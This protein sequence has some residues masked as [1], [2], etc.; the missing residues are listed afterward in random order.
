M[1]HFLTP[2]MT[3]FRCFWGG[4][5]GTPKMHNFCDILHISELHHFRRIPQMS[6]KSMK[7]LWQCS[8]LLSPSSRDSMMTLRKSYSRFYKISVTTLT[9]CMPPE[10]LKSLENFRCETFLSRETFM[11][12]VTVN[13]IEGRSSEQQNFTFAISVTRRKN[14]PKRCRSF[15]PNSRDNAIRCERPEIPPGNKD[16]PMGRGGPQKTAAPA[17]VR[18]CG[19]TQILDPKPGNWQNPSIRGFRGPPPRGVQKGSFLGYYWAFR[20]NNTPKMAIFGGP[21]RN[22]SPARGYAL[23]HIFFLILFLIFFIL[24]FH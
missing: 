11:D 20:P 22:S 16:H 8:W 5:P 3:K 17:I 24:F 14:S 23:F 12:H 10:F 9:W 7:S 15:E 18:I 6:S 4:P 19:G 1:G 21:G 2:K 13:E